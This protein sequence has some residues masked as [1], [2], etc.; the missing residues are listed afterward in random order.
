VR[1]WFAKMKHPASMAN[2][3]HIAASIIT[4]ICPEKKR[5]K[6]VSDTSLSDVI[7]IAYLPLKLIHTD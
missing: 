6:K 1:A 7:T 3:S 5:E 4:L 2:V